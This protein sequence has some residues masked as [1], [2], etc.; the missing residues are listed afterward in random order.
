MKKKTTYLLAGVFCFPGILLFLDNPTQKDVVQS[1][2]YDA[3]LL[4]PVD[5]HQS[6]NSSNP[7]WKGLVD[8]REPLQKSLSDNQMTVTGLR[9]DATLEEG[10][11]INVQTLIV[12]ARH[13][14]DK[15]EKPALDIEPINLYKNLSEKEKIALVC[16]NCIKT[17]EHISLLSG[18][19]LDTEGMLALSKNEDRHYMLRSPMGMFIPKAFNALLYYEE[20]TGQL[21]EA[22]ELQEFLYSS[23]YELIVEYQNTQNSRSIE[24]GVFNTSLDALNLNGFPDCVKHWIINK[25]VNGTNLEIR[26][27]AWAEHECGTGVR[28]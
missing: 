22:E 10:A 28:F 18:N 19:S 13:H 1:Q 8:N 6:S 5:Q 15:L 24:T 17:M 7:L 9:L 4:N 21:L 23:A 11:S 25:Q 2:T 27:L 26:D 20:M 14:D 12:D 16:P 3:I